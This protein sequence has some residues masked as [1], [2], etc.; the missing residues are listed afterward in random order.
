MP[1]LFSS[2]APERARPIAANPPVGSRLG[3]RRGVPS[4]ALAALAGV[5]L[6][7]LAGCKLVD[8]TTFAPAPAAR[9]RDAGT[10]PA[11]PAAKIDARTPLLTI[12]PD[13]PVSGYRSLLSF[14]VRAAEQRDR[15]VRFD[16]TA[17]APAHLA[18]ARQTA[19]TDAAE[20]QATEVMR[21]MVQAGVPADRILLRVVLDPAT[22]RHAVQVYVR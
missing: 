21:A 11:V 9:A 4:C 3:R 7:A 17:V 10:A 14:A 6:F 19:E 13:T 22:T 1:S 2:R 8:Q 5:G 15:N 20:T 16:V 18:P 12:G